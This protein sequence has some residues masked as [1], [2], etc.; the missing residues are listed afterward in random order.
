MCGQPANAATIKAQQERR[1]RELFDWQGKKNTYRSK[2]TAFQEGLDWK[3]IGHSRAR[4]AISEAT[5]DKQSEIF[6]ITEAAEQQYYSRQRVDEGNEARSAGRNEA[7][8]FLAEASKREE[9]MDSLY[10]DAWKGERLANQGYRQQVNA[11]YKKLG[12]APVAPLLQRVD[13]PDRSSQFLQAA[14]IGLTIAGAA[15]TG[16]ASLGF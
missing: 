2:E 3:V 5:F 13:K 4:S 14:K 12:V 9:A 7:L 8:A 15:A 16:G 10:D 11:L 6:K 1:N